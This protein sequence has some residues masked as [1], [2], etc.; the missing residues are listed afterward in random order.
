V[1]EI[2]EVSFEGRS[3]DTLSIQNVLNSGG[4]LKKYKSKVMRSNGVS[5][6]W[7]SRLGLIRMTRTHE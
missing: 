5:R 3:L 2:L 6:T 1:G 7:E 4:G